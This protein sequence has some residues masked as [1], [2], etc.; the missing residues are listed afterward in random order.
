MARPDFS[1]TWRFDRERSRLE[2]PAPD[3]TLLV[4]EH[5]EPALRITRT[6]VAGDK[7]ETFSIDLTT[8]GREVDLTGGDVRLRG[9]AYWD[10]DTLVFDTQLE[11]G[12]VSGTNVV[13]YTL[14]ADGAS[15]T[16]EER[17]R[18]AALNY[19]NVWVMDRQSR[20]E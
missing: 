13:R 6:H 18:S 14:A 3:S 7:S 15:F 5:R 4:I 11:R 12:G 20:Q 16:A 10:L 8:D 9:R 19:D 1:G 17:F 2:I